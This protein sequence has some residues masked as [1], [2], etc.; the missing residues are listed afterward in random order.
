MKYVY[1]HSEELDSSGFL[2]ELK[3]SVAACR[4]YALKKREV[5]EDELEPTLSPGEASL[6]TRIWEFWKPNSDPDQRPAKSGDSAEEKDEREAGDGTGDL[7]QHE[8]SK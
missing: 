8:G 3:K 6:C 5:T 2:Q 4:E 1:A 7:P